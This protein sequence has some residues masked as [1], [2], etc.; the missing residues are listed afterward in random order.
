MEIVCNSKTLLNLLHAHEMK[1]K[2]LYRSFHAQ[3]TNSGSVYYD[4]RLT[5]VKETHVALRIFIMQVLQ[6]INFLAN[7]KDELAFYILA[8]KGDMLHS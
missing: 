4:Q 7:K 6:K 5:K 1:R 8:S 2:L 3:I